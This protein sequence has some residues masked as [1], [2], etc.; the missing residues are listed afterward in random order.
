M[1]FAS[2]TLSVSDNVLVEVHTDEG[3]VGTAEAVS[4]PFAGFYGESQLS[5][6]HAIE[7]WFA[8]ALI[9]LDP[10]A[11]ERA[12]A[13]FDG[14]E[15]NNTA[16]AALDI[17]LHDIMGQAAGVSC[18]RLLG[19]W[20]DAVSMTYICGI[21]SPGAM[22]DEA[23][24]VRESHGI[25]SFKLKVGISARQ[26]ENM[27]VAMRKAL[28][29]ATLNIDGNQGLSASEALR[30]LAVAS[31]VEVAW[32]EEPCS[33]HDRV[34]RQRV[35]AASQV[36]VL[37]DES[38]RTPEEVAREIGDRSVHMAAIKTART[39][40]HLSRRIVNACAASRI[41]VISASQADSG[42][43]LTAGWHF[44]AANR[45]TNT[46]PAELSFFLHLTDDILA[47]PL[48]V[49]NGTM[50]LPEVPGLGIEIDREKLAHYT[51]K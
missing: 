47:K 18:R 39:G 45:A 21:G 11:I 17:A 1:V 49:R 10:F 51:T 29:N 32:A 46:K 25:N 16:K 13:V 44:A 50:A 24:S 23:L 8:P 22:A 48:V 43:G 7:K 33:V 20:A 4:R 14:V 35:A 34:G 26:D 28:P 9:G 15:H 6:L 12:W 27:L 19:G 31:E 30:V 38:C 42:V 2:G 37:G 40:F 5:I 36:P 41:G 3:L